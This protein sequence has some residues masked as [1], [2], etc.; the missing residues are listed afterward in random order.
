MILVTGAAG[1]AGSRIVARLVQ[2]GERPRGLVR[3][4]T[5]ARD[6]LPADGVELVRGDTTV[7]ETLAGAVEGVD[8]IIHTAFITADRKQGPS[9]NYWQTNVIGTQNLLEAAHKAGVTRIVELG[10]LGTRPASHGSYMETRH[11]AD[12]HIQQSG[13]AWSIL[14]PSIQFGPGAAFFKGLADLIR[15][16]PVVPMV[17]S[18]SRRFQPIWVEDVVTCLLKMAREPQTYDGQYIEIGGPDIYTYARILDLLMAKM[19]AHKLK[20]PGPLPAVRLGAA[21]L[22]AVL[23]RPPLTPAAVDL[24]TFDNVTALD[25]V[26]SRFGF[27]PRSLPD[28]L[29]EHGV[30]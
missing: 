25:S 26:P 15:R 27:T 29:S 9:V 23:P 19:G 2:E 21:V 28:Y 22:S 17:G 1:F 14:G 16:M 30:D 18:G 13:L 11:V 24:F 7:P 8:T 4:L 5:R 10:G 20:V 6:R 12:Q 3:D